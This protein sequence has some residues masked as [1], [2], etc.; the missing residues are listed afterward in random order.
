MDDSFKEFLKY[1]VI[2]NIVFIPLLWWIMNSPLKKFWTSPK[3]HWQ[4]L[5]TFIVIELALLFVL[6][7]ALALVTGL[8]ILLLAPLLVVHTFPLFN[9][10]YGLYV[11]KKEN[12]KWF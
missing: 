4:Q 5:I 6:I 3:E 10:L 12:N 1:A 9:G 7:P 2:L 11:F 8:F